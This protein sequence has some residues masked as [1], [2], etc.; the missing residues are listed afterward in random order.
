MFMLFVGEAYYAD[1]P[2]NGVMRCF[3]TFEEAVAEGERQ[4][5]MLMDWY[6]IF[7]T[8]TREFV[9]VEGDCYEPW[10]KPSWEEQDAN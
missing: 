2:S 9:A 6:D 5:E 4:L 1:R 8:E 3:D 7:N 10:C